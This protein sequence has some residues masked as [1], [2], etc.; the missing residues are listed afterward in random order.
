MKLEQ[1]RDPRLN[2]TVISIP[3]L[4][5]WKATMGVRQKISLSAFLIMNVWL[6]IIA[7]VRVSLFKRGN[8][9]DLTWTLFFQFLEPNVAIVAACFTAFRSIFVNSSIKVRKP[10]RPPYSLRRRLFRSH[11]PNHQPLDDLPTIPGAT[12]TGVRTQIWNNGRT[13]L[14]DATTLDLGRQGQESYDGDDGI[15]VYHAWSMN[16]SQV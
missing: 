12:L 16:S 7:I 14:T 2:S 11:P 9:F 6:I 1:T 15:H 5:L 13:N 10:D 4:V 8:T 3:T